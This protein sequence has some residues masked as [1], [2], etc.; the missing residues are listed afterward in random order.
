[1]K[2]R[3]KKMEKNL[4]LKVN[5]IEVDIFS[6]LYETNKTLFS[7]MK[8]LYGDTLSMANEH[9]KIHS[10]EKWLS[11]RISKLFENDKSSTVISYI[12]YMFGK[13]WERY[14]SAL[15][16]NY[17]P[18]ENVRWTENGSHD[19]H[20][21]DIRK[22]TNNKNNYYDTTENKI[23]NKDSSNVSKDYNQFSSKDIDSN[24]EASSSAE[25]IYGF[26]SSIGV[27]S[28]RTDDRNISTKTIDSTSNE[29]N[30]SVS[31][32]NEN[33]KEKNLTNSQEKTD[34]NKNVNREL[35]RESSNSRKRNGI[36]K[37]SNQQLLTEELELRKNLFL[38][39]VFNDIDSFITI[40]C[41]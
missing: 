29:E 32:N 3:K 8:T 37:T 35:D 40:P 21:M 27:D 23:T 2:V 17:T 9:Y 38:D 10:G 13:K 5:D 41:Y 18:N 22:E 14:W 16:L 12:S 30:K 39:I 25:S 36:D 26:N 34:E 1:M 6:S 4:I 19:L 15:D 11:Y 33:L 31:S 7:W 24:D 28:N 20:D